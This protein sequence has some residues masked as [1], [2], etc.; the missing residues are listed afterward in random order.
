MGKEWKE[1]D[2]GRGRRGK[3]ERDRIMKE[4]VVFIVLIERPSCHARKF[5]WTLL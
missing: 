4:K 5:P 1:E 3:G 2:E